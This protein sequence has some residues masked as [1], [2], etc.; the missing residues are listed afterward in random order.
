M[1]TDKDYEDWSGKLGIKFNV[2]GKVIR[3]IRN[4]YKHKYSDY[5]LDHFIEVVKQEANRATKEIKRSNKPL[6]LDIVFYLSRDVLGMGRAISTRDHVNKL[7]PG[8]LGG[9][10]ELGYRESIKS[11]VGRMTKEQFEEIIADIPDLK[12]IGKVEFIA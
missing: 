5:C 4:V 1:L 8:V 7:L 2:S 11:Y 10:E 3:H 12:P 6:I 9:I